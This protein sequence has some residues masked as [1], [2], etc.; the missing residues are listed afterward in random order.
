MSN[1]F[2]GDGYVPDLNQISTCWSV[3]H[4]PAHFVH[5][6][7]PAI[8]KYIRALINDPHDADEILQEFLLQVTRHGFQRASP[9]RGRFR[10]YLITSVRNAVRAYQARQQGRPAP[11]DLD[12]DRLPDNRFGSAEAQLL[13]G[14][15]RCLLDAAWRGLEAHEKRSPGNF[16]HTVLRMAVDHPECDSRDLA[17]RVS[18]KAGTTIRPEAFR[19]QLSR[20]RRLF[21]QFIWYEV[22]QTLD[23]PAP[24]D[25][26]AELFEVGLMSYVRPFLATSEE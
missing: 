19:K 17:Q 18:Q 13:A 1:P 7:A 15:Q 16:A 11:V 5:R 21:A 20:A 10:F 23:N 12:A 24:A 26:E 8:Q 3:I 2:S 22:E 4:E 9:D 25:V 14:W 6:Y